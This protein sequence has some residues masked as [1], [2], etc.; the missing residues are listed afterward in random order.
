M[1]DRVGPSTQP[2]SA[3]PSDVDLEKDLEMSSLA[4]LIEQVEPAKA[5]DVAIRPRGTMTKVIDFACILLN[6]VSTVLLV[7]INKWYLLPHNL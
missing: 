4:P 5:Q 1:S 3:M 7:F 6:I 2:I